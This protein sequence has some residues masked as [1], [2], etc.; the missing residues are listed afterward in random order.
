MEISIERLYV[1]ERSLYKILV[2][3]TATMSSGM[4]LQAPFTLTSLPRPFDSQRGK[5]WATPVYGYKSQK[6]RKRP[7]V[8]VG[9]DGE[10]ISVYNVRLHSSITELC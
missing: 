7:E 9:V 10:G 3:A 1:C 6:R 2:Q 8:V 5:T 4:A